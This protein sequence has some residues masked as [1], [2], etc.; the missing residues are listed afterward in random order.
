MG[1]TI[2]VKFISVD[3]ANKLI[4]QIRKYSGESISKVKKQIENQL[5]VLT[6]D[7]LK[8]PEKLQDL[9]DTIKSFEKI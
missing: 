3:N 4:P 7:Y 2:E 6:W 1:N 9:L 8:T 5:P